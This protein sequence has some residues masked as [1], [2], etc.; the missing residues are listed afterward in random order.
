[1]TSAPSPPLPCLLAQQLR[2]EKFQLQRPAEWST[3]LCGGRTAAQLAAV[4]AAAAYRICSGFEWADRGWR[5][6]GAEGQNHN[7][8]VGGSLAVSDSADF[9]SKVF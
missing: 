3:S 5:E 1:M 8:M 6:G 2:I 7:R 4:V 9:S